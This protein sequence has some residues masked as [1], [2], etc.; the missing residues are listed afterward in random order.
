MTSA[1]QPAEQALPR[2]MSLSGWSWAIFE[3]GRDPYLIL[4]SVY[5]FMPYFTSVIVG[6]PVRGQAMVANF[7]KGAG[8][9]VAL[10]VPLLGSLVDRL[11]GRKPLL[12]LV[13]AV[14]VPLIASL[15]WARPDGSGLSVMTILF[16]A[17]TLNILFAYSSVI[18]NALLVR[19]AGPHTGRASGMALM[20]ANL[21]GL[22]SLAFVLWAFVL[23]GKTDWSLIPATPLFGLDSAMH[24]PD[25]A[26]AWVT[27]ALL[28]AG[29]IPLV[30]FTPDVE[31][32]GARL[33]ESIRQTFGDLVGMLR[34]L[35]GERNVTLYLVAHIFISDAIGAV[36]MFLGIYAAGVMQWGVLQ[37]LVFAIWQSCFA[38]LGGLIGGQIDERW[39]PK[40]A[41]QLALLG[42]LASTAGI[43]GMSRDRILYAW[44]YDRVQGAA[45]SVGP[46]SVS[47]PELIFL[48]FSGGVVL[49]ATVAAGSGR[50]LLLL[51]TPRDRSGAYFGLFALAGTVTAWLGPMLVAMFTA[52][53]ASQQMG[54]V[55]VAGLLVLGLVCIH[56][57]STPKHSA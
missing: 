4:V 35:K 43:I 41:L 10:T 24:E 11:G 14:S 39:G 40:V 23:P 37:M 17:T 53:F 49:W 26:V 33:G 27:M 56:L 44:D 22:V 50:T 21:V 52:A 48:L 12:L 6:D 30:L 9:I 19:A 32:T 54:F 55:P 36:A 8:V 1:V 29:A 31:T 57:V 25:R 7:A 47:A 5:I 3:G 45:W 20:L 46:F 28:I 2:R 42:A 51:I 18:H 38:S 16:V 15:W 13:T 34:A